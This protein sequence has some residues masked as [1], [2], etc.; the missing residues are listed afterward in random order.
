MGLLS[1]LGSVKALCFGG[2]NKIDLYELENFSLSSFSN[3]PVV[4]DLEEVR[5]SAEELDFSKVMGIS[6]EEVRKVEDV[7]ARTELE[8][9]YSLFESGGRE[10]IVSKDGGELKLGFKG[11]F[12]DSGNFSCVYEVIFMSGERKAFKKPLPS[13]FAKGLSDIEKENVV[14]HRLDSRC[15]YDLVCS[16]RGEVVGSLM[17]KFDGDWNSEIERVLKSRVGVVPGY[18][19]RHYNFMKQTSLELSRIHDKDFI[20]GDVKL[21][22]IFVK[23]D[24]ARICDCGGVKDKD[25]ILSIFERS[26]PKIER[27]SYFSRQYLWCIL[28]SDLMGSYTDGYIA[29]GD[30]SLLQGVLENKDIDRYF[31][32]RQKQDIFALGVSFMTSMLMGSI[33]SRFGSFGITAAAG[34]LERYRHVALYNGFKEDD[35]KFVKGMLGKSPDSRPS[36]Q[37]V[38]D[39][40]N[41]SG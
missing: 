17:E 37:E 10:Y 23:G 32:L 29:E 28:G 16:N 9:G 34:T 22:N 8:T 4:K 14:F 41:P 33:D 39:F 24:V 31:E 21:E 11:R 7:V 30:N 40:F 36:A 13:N 15:D 5:F 35:I 25:E 2:E 18:S 20:H 38:A 1:I 26:L 3:G 12:L 6:I 19:L 27:A